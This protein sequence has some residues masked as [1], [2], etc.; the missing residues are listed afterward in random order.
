MQLLHM[1]L[2]SHFA[3]PSIQS[4]PLHLFLSLLDLPL[5]FFNQVR[6]LYILLPNTVIQLLRFLRCKTFSTF[7]NS[8]YLPLH[9]LNFILKHFR[10][11]RQSIRRLSKSC[12]HIS[13][14]ICHKKFT[15][16]FNNETVPL[17]QVIP[18][19]ISSLNLIQTLSIDH[20]SRI[21]ICL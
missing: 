1:M 6:Q 17:L 21:L 3:I 10:L 13:L 15:S 4:Y 8:V 5:S 7:N 19:I 20:H 11:I 2:S 12:S 14:R 9:N 16:T 18:T